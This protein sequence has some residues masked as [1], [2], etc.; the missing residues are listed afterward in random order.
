MK[1]SLGRM[2]AMFM[3]YLYLHQRSVSRVLELVFWPVMELVVWGFVA[4]YIRQMVP[5]PVGQA[6]H[7]LISAI[8][9]WDLFYRSQQGVTLSFIEDI[10]TQNILNILISPLRLHEWLITTFVYGM[11]KTLL[12]SLILS[13]LAYVFYHFHIVS[14]LGFYLIPFVFSLLLFGWTLGVFTSGLLIRWGHS[15]EALIW[16]I[17]FL[18]QPL[19]AIYYPLFILP[20]WCQVLARALPSTYVFEGMRAVMAT[21]KMPYTFFFISLGLNLVYFFVA[22]MFFK[23]MY[24]SSRKSGRLGRLGLD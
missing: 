15:V 14:Y 10:W 7:F 12:I 6:I 11:F 3:R 21:G 20:G 13:C 8:I 4:L 17:P 9:F 5:G 23:L 24:Q 16:G 2:K 18:V 1:A 19:S 22:S